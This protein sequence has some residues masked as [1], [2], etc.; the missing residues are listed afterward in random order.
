MPLSSMTGFARSA[1][2]A[3]ES[4]FSW[5][6]KS[7][8]ARGLEIRLRLPPGLDHLEPAIRNRI[9]EHLSRGSCFF[10]LQKEG[11]AESPR[12]ALNEE[13]LAIVIAAA[14]RLAAEEGIGMPSSDGLLAIPGVLQDRT[15]RG[16][17]EAAESR[18]AAILDALV[19]AIGALKSARSEEGARLAAV[20]EDQL[21]AITAPVSARFLIDHDLPSTY[22]ATL[23]V[24][25]GA[26]SW[27]AVRMDRRLPGRTPVRTRTSHR[28]NRRAAIRSTGTRPAFDT[29]F[30]S[31]K[32]DR[33][34]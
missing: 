25:C 4:G 2:E 5:E 10:S 27:L 31:S 3:G 15:D 23:P 1:F 11:G 19:S 32:T 12:L 14:R 28:P 26:F 33:I 20:L 13:A 18:D 22:V 30:G 17:G 34:V 6:L 24:G 8:N 21:A 7:V 16:N 9:R 29:T